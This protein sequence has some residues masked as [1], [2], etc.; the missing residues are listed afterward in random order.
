MMLPNLTKEK[1]V[2]EV[3]EKKD[4]ILTLIESTDITHNV[5]C[6]LAGQFFWLGAT[7]GKIREFRYARKIRIGRIDQ[8]RAS[9]C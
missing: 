6:I 9:G 2:S 5:V 4:F 1:H 8:Y 3:C 7:F